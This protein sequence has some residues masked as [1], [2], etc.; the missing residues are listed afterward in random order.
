MKTLL[1]TYQFK[2]TD[3]EKLI[4]KT[5]NSGSVNDIEKMTR[6]NSE[7]NQYRIFICVLENAIKKEE[8]LEKEK[9]ERVATLCRLYYNYKKTSDNDIANYLKRIKIV[10]R[11][12]HAGGKITKYYP[13]NAKAMKKIN[14][15]PRRNSL[16]F[17][18]IEVTTRAINGLEVYKTI[19]YLCKSNS[20]FILKPDIGEIFDAINFHDLLRNDTFDAICFLDGYETLPNTDGE[21]HIMQAILLTNPK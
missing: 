8:K 21:H 9:D 18:A 5:S 14:A 4:E 11:E 19:T 17:D 16:T 13:L 2:L 15:A 20:R 7:A 12:K 3:V 1:E 10:K 6:L